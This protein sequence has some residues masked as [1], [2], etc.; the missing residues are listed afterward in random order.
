M[1]LPWVM[2]GLLLQLWSANQKA[3]MFVTHDLEEAI[4]LADRVVIMSAGP[5]ARIIGDFS[6]TLQRS[7]DIADIKLDP[8]F[9][10]VHKEIWRMLKA[11]VMKAYPDLAEGETR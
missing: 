3:V 6:I 5:S 2:G 7:R 8:A 1:R 11:E 9:Q 10:R 4:S